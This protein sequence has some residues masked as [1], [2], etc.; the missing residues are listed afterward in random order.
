MEAV[1]RCMLLME[2]YH[3]MI[4]MGVARIT[5]VVLIVLI[6]IL[7]GEGCVVHRAVTSCNNSRAEERPV[8]VGPSGGGY[9]HRLCGVVCHRDQSPGIDTDGCALRM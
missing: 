5:G 7:W 4:V 3:P 2:S 1:T 6:V 9:T 8:V